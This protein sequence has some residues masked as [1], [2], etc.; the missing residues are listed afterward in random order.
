LLDVLVVPQCFQ[1][2]IIH[3]VA[4]MGERTKH[5]SHVKKA[6]SEIRGSTL[7]LLV[8]SLTGRR[9]AQARRVPADS[10]DMYFLATINLP[11]FRKTKACTALRKASD[12]Y[13][14]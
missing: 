1:Q 12:M 6:T 11:C 9:Y 3:K 4:H 7:P 2:K 10:K 13:W 8:V 5:Q 14:D